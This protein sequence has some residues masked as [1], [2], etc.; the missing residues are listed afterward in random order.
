MAAIV[1]MAFGFAC[2]SGV[3]VVSDW[4]KVRRPFHMGRRPEL[5][6]TV[7]A[8]TWALEDLKFLW[9][10]ERLTLVDEAGLRHAGSGGDLLPDQALAAA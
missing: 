1:W 6:S 7:T 2:V 3:M 10:A 9:A 5:Q 4:I 8:P